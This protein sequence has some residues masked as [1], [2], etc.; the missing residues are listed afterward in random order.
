MITCPRQIKEQNYCW[1]ASRLS[2]KTY[3]LNIFLSD[4]FPILNDTDIARD[5]DDNT[6]DKACDNIDAAVKVLRKL[7]KKLLNRFNK[8][9]RKGNAGK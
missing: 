2:N 7:A 6:L 1:S 5:G 4:L 3:F 8:N 9:K